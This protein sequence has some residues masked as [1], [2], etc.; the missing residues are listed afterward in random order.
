[1]IHT[2]HMHINAVFFRVHAAKNATQTEEN[3]G[4][5]C[6]FE[7]LQQI[8]VE[9]KHPAIFI[10]EIYNAIFSSSLWLNVESVWQLFSHSHIL[11]GL[12]LAV[13]K[14]CAE[15]THC[16]TIWI[17]LSGTHAA[18]SKLTFV[19]VFFLAVFRLFVFSL[20]IRWIHFKTVFKVFGVFR[21]LVQQF[22]PW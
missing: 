14:K 15:W 9:K 21:K 10:V 11:F 3:V 7:R 18:H 5:S 2:T 22:Q 6:V 13:E 4:A 19:T 20:H 12:A 16:I 17:V 8:E 1:M